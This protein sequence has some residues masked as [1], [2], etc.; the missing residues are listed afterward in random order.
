VEPAA[1]DSGAQPLEA[2]A[3]VPRS[4]S[5]LS[6]A[7]AVSAA[8]WL[9]QWPDWLRPVAPQALLLTLASLLLAWLLST[10]T[11]AR[12]N[13]L[14]TARKPG[15]TRPVPTATCRRGGLPYYWKQLFWLP[16]GA[17]KT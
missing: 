2:D 15:R 13:R 4:S 10:L 3:A 17:P 12:R 7:Y 5:A 6:A 1:A 9:Y 8:I 14:P 11:L 16:S